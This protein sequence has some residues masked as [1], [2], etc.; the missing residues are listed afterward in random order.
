MFENFTEIFSLLQELQL[1]QYF[2]LYFKITPKKW[3]VTCYVHCSWWQSS[4]EPTLPCEQ[5]HRPIM[6][7]ET[8]Q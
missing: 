7:S 3:T 2:I 6:E 5:D 1:L 8:R 4:L